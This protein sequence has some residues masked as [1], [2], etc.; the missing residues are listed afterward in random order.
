MQFFSEYLGLADFRYFSICFAK[1]RV[2]DGRDRVFADRFDAE[3]RGGEFVVG[4][5]AVDDGF[6]GAVEVVGLG[7]GNIHEIAAGF[8]ADSGRAIAWI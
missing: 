3:E 1:R 8:V 5:P 6:D 7:F 2:R 4:E